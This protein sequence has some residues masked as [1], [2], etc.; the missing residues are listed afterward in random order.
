MATSQRA[1]GPGGKHHEQPSSV[2]MWSV[3]GSR[4]GFGSYLWLL[5]RVPPAQLS[6]YAFVNPIVA[7]ILGALRRALIGAPACV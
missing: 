3:F 1:C 6:T 4:L 2:W 7:V 5:Q